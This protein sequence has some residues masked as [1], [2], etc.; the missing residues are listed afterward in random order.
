MSRLTKAG[1]GRLS[2][3]TRLCMGIAA[4]I[5]SS[6]ITLSIRAEMIDTDGDGM[7]DDYEA[8]FALNPNDSSDAALDPDGDGL[9]NLAESALWTDP[10]CSDTDRDGWNDSQDNTPLSRAFIDWGNPGFTNGDIYTYT[11][12][13]WWTEAAKSGGQWLSDAWHV[14]ET[15]S[16][17]TGALLID[18]DPAGLS[19]NLMMRLTLLDAAGATLYVDLL[20]ASQQ[21]LVSSVD[22]NLVQGTDQ[23]VQILREIPL[24]DYPDTA[25]IRL[26]RGT[27]AVTVY[28]TILFID[29]DQDGLDADQ[30][31]Q[32]GSSDNNPDSD[33]DGLTDYA[34]VFTHGSSPTSTDS[35]GDGLADDWEVANGFNP[36]GSVDGCVGL[37]KFDEGA[38]SVAMDASGLGND[39]VVAGATYHNLVSG[40]ALVFDGQD[41]DVIITNSSDYKTPAFTLL[42][43]L[44][45]DNPF[46]NTVSGTAGEGDMVVASQ[47]NSVNSLAYSL[48]RTGRGSVRFTMSDGTL[49]TVLETPDSFLAAGKW[50]TVAIAFQRPT[51]SLFV[52]GS[53][54][55]TAQQ[56]ADIDYDTASGLLL[57]HG[58]DG[59]GTD[60]FLAGMLDSVAVY[61]RVLSAEEVDWASEA[62]SDS[63]ND[64][65][66]NLSEAAAGTEP[67][68]A[69]TDGDRLSDYLEITVYGSDPF[70]FD[71][72]RDGKPDGWEYENGY[73]P[74]FN[75]DDSCL[76][77]WKLD[78]AEGALVS[79][80][81]GYENHGTATGTR[82]IDAV[83]NKGRAFDGVDD[84]VD[85]AN[86][87]IYKPSQSFTVSFFAQ[88]TDPFG[89]TTTGNAPDGTMVLLSQ[90][91]AGGGYAYAVYKTERNALIFE[92][93]NTTTSTTIATPDGFIVPGSWAHVAV[94]FDRPQLTFY[95]NG[96]LIG[97]A[98]HDADLACSPDHG[99]TLGH[100]NLTDD[101]FMTGFFDDLR[102]YGLALT[103]TRIGEFLLAANYDIS[104]FSNLV[105]TGGVPE[106]RTSHRTGTSVS[107]WATV[108]EG[109]QFL[110][111]AGDTAAIADVN[112][113]ITQ[114]TLDADA[115]ISVVTVPAICTLTVDS[116][117]GDPQG[118]GDY[119]YGTTA[120]WSVTSP[121]TIA[122]GY[123]AVA[124]VASGSETLTLD[125][126]VTV[127]WTT[128]YLLTVNAAAN[129]T[130]D[131]VTSWH[132]TGSTV[133]LTATPDTGY[134]FV[135]WQGD[136]PAG[137][138]TANPLTVTM[139][140]ARTLTPV[141]ALP[142]ELVLSTSSL[143]VPEGD[144][145][146]FTVSL[147]QAV[148]ADVA[149]TAAIVDG[150]DADLTVQ[151]GGT[152]TF[153][154]ANWDTPQT[155]TIAAAEDE[156]ISYETGTVRVSP[157]AANSVD[158]S[159]T[160]IDNETTDT[161]S[162]EIP[163]GW[164][165]NYG[166]DP[167]NADDAWQDLDSDG[168]TNLREYQLGTT[169]IDADSDGDGLID[170]EDPYPLI[171]AEGEEPVITVTSPQSG[172][173]FNQSTVQVAFSVACDT[174]IDDVRV[175]S[176]LVARTTGTFSKTL[177]LSDGAQNIYIRAVSLEGRAASVTIPIVVDAYPSVVSIISPA[178]NEAI[179]EQNVYVQ[180]RTECLD[181]EIT[182][183][184][185]PAIRNGYMCYAWIRFDSSGS[186]TIAVTCNGNPSAD[187][188]VVSYTPP[189]GYDPAADDDGDGVPNQTDLFSND[190]G[191]SADSDGDGVGDAYDPQPNNASV[192][193]VVTITT[194]PNGFKIISN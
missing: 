174:Q 180:V 51:M 187:S 40:A 44:R 183:N 17:D 38:G 31:T 109:R 121:W 131:Q 4:L 61:N 112:Q 75:F 48:V 136:V 177:T 1:W 89:N 62:D 134:E 24:V 104:G 157:I 87:D 173:I 169:P 102:I 80:S 126:T 47:K 5:I 95:V 16:A 175:N 63:D 172:Q 181:D 141:F 64:G 52:N 100:A 122:T 176:A 137:Q 71:T 129:G 8:F 43:V 74:T 125:K 103:S 11:G 160:V 168:L 113:P 55:T 105:V 49:T 158:V 138:E 110:N 35:D 42:A 185:Q 28:D 53:L 69:D 67:R 78:E 190:P 20:D 115:A 41:D 155:V 162:D 22:G 34:E 130:V 189:S 164:E 72:D 50:Y 150:G 194:P 151:S 156:N 143:S 147:S 170:G 123:Q 65:L 32:L 36:G 66:S 39:G 29:Q 128:Q 191:A 166:L 91:N 140:Q 86:S 54:V 7:G 30:E 58:P 149:V 82:V 186:Q 33:N 6:W 153:T 3:A 45:T 133:D 97:T 83:L 116:T 81:S 192:R 60:A 159:V 21:V 106:G 25:T 124:D 127:N 152:L 59:A 68:S 154:S 77:H 111:W 179:S 193:S 79:D 18:I 15:D 10:N 118:A 108:P 119:N 107:I 139:D 27:G 98:S 163:D 92:L 117:Y 132:N 96:E 178:D 46:G 94:T 101:G 182:I 99:L 145:S 85:I 188:V 120:N 167:G 165:L 14:P 161:D 2:P 148:S 13:D 9:T 73:D 76:G 26:R 114:I 37:W 84:A 56:D 144:I 184:G 171:P 142:F 93:S 88:I 12:P 90:K 146:S 70:H 19:T 57:G 135:M 23:A